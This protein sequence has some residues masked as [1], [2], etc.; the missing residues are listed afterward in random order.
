MTVTDHDQPTPAPVPDRPSRT[1]L[2]ARRRAAPAARFE[3]GRVAEARHRNPTWIV[4]GLLLVLLSA[5]GGVL[6]FTSTDDR[7]DVLVAAHDLDPGRPVERDDLRIQRV[8]LDANVSSLPVAAA[9]GL[10][11]QHPIGPIPS[12][13]MLSAAMFEPAVALA[14]DEVVVGAALDPGEAPLSK[15]TVG[16]TVE[17][18]KVSVPGP[19]TAEVDGSAAPIGTGAVWAVEELASGQLWV[20]VRAKSDVGMQAS[21]AAAQD[22]LRVVLIGGTG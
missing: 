16:A 8:G 18:V 15:L 7:T 9:V 5:L 20:S 21:A 4:A 14:P 1:G 10:V 13:T 19:G 3:P 12:G 6:L 11:G 17:L 2:L 22:R